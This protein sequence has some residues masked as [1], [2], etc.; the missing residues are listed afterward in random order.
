[1]TRTNLLALAVLCAAAAVATRLGGR[2]GMGVVAGALSGA[3]VSLL[4]GAWMRHTIR[5]RPHKTMAAF[6]ES[7]LFKL[8]FVALGVVSFRYISAAHA[9]VD[10]QSFLVAFAACVFIVHTLAVA[11]NVKLLQLTKTTPEGPDAQQPKGSNP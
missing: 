3:G 11:E 4:G 5:T 9:R 1:V 7:F 8:V 10:W 6:V 2:E